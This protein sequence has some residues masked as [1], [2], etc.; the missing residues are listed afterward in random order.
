[1]CYLLL[2][3]RPYVMVLFTRPLGWLMLG[4]GVVILSVGSFWMSRIIKVEV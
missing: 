4:G 3:N 2:A 1:M